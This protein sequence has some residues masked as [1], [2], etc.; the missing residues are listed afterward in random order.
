MVQSS[1]YV[2]KIETNGDEEAF[3]VAN[4]ERPR[5]SKENDYG[6]VGERSSVI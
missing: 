4:E 2:R 1:T 6:N 3:G 5:R